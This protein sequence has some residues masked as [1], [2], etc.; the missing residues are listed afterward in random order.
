M[1]NVFLGLVNE[2]GMVCRQDIWKIRIIR[3][4]LIAK[5]EY[6]ATLPKICNIPKEVILLTLFSQLSALWAYGSY[7]PALFIQT[8]QVLFE[9]QALASGIGFVSQ[10]FWGGK[11]I[12]PK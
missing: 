7:S 1:L 3:L 12:G 11:Q 9:L 10:I 4:L 5:L 2:P 8:D 6:L